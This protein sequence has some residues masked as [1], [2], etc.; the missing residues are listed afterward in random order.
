[1]LQKLFKNHS[2]NTL[3][4]SLKGETSFSFHPIWPILY[5]ETR[6]ERKQNLLRA[7]FH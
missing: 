3:A 1:M 2:Q 7:Q 5:G 4:N 6:H